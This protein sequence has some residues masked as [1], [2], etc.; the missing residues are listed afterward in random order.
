MRRKDKNEV[1]VAESRERDGERYA[2]KE[3]ARKRRAF[4]NDKK[5][6]R[7]FR[8]TLSCARG[9]KTRLSLFLSLSLSLDNR[10]PRPLSRRRAFSP[11][12]SPCVS[13][14]ARTRKI[15]LI[16]IIRLS[17]SESAVSH[18][19]ASNVRL[20]DRKEVPRTALCSSHIVGRNLTT[21]TFQTQF[22]NP[23]EFQKSNG[24]KNPTELL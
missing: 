16:I 22:E 1:A 2:E 23:T 6:E 3:A 7:E 10:E 5:P 19:I 20:F 11:E 8:G 14:R 24:I 12:D 15:I 17:V 21:A 13:N 4:E 9:D 18:A